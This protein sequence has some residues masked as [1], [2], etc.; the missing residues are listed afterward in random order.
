MV[1]CEAEVGFG[2][3]C[4]FF[5]FSRVGYF[6]DVVFL[7]I[8]VNFYSAEAV[9]DRRKAVPEQIG[10]VFFGYVKVVA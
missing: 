2:Y 7:K 8:S 6:I 9:E 4:E 1:F 3:E 5:V 10:L